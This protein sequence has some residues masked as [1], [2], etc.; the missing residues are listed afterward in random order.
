MLKIPNRLSRELFYTQMDHNMKRIAQ[1]VAVIACTRFAGHCRGSQQSTP[2]NASMDT[3]IRHLASDY[4]AAWSSQNAA[5]VA[6]HYAPDG[7]SKS[8]L[9]HRPSDERPSL[10]MRRVS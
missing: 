5:S 9:G 3:I 10:L 1:I 4:A 8:T 6:A 7:S 2:R